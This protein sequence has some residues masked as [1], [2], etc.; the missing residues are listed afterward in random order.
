MSTLSHYVSLYN[1]IN[2]TNYYSILQLRKQDLTNISNKN[3]YYSRLNRTLNTRDCLSI[4][5]TSLLKTAY[6]LYKQL[7]GN[8]KAFG[9]NT[10]DLIKCGHSGVPIMTGNGLFGSLKSQV[11]LSTIPIKKRNS[12]KVIQATLEKL[13]FGDNNFV[14]I[15]K[16]KNKQLGYLDVTKENNDIHIDF[17]TNI[18]GRKKYKNIENILVQGMV[19]DCLKQG[20]VPSLKAVAVDVGK[21]MGRGYHNNSLYKRMGM[22]QDDNGFMYMQK[23]KVLELINKRIEKFGKLLNNYLQ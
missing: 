6:R 17:M 23:E 12:N 4:P 9:V 16:N 8:M 18:I 19:E 7:K 22:K 3:L 5:Q 11:T 21:R 14:Y 15:L 2:K 10:F 20:F 13:D 1:K